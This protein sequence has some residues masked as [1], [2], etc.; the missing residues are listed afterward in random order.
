[1]ALFGNRQLLINVELEVNRYCVT[2]RLV[3]GEIRTVH[4]EA[5]TWPDGTPEQIAN[6]RIVF[7]MSKQGDELTASITAKL[8]TN[9]RGTEFRTWMQEV[10]QRG[11][12]KFIER[13]TYGN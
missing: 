9:S 7:A 12:K 13:W 5:K 8:A 1:M 6:S 3:T 4:P 2:S 11:S 10:K